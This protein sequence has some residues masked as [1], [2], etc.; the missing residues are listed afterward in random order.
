MHFPVVIRG[1]F[2]ASFLAFIGIGL[3]DNADDVHDYVAAVDEGN[4]AGGDLGYYAF[5]KGSPDA[6][7]KV[8]QMMKFS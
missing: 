6:L 8:S 3:G 5:R 1:I 7:P 4:Q 2:C